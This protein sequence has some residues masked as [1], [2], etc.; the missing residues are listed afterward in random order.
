MDHKR[1]S[2]ILYHVQKLFPRQNTTDAIEV[3]LVQRI[4]SYSNKDKW[5]ELGNQLTANDIVL[6]PNGQ[7]KD[8]TGREICEKIVRYFN[9]EYW[10]IALWDLLCEDAK[11]SPI[12][13]EI[14][15]AFIKH[16]ISTVAKNLISFGPQLITHKSI[17]DD[18]L[19]H[20]TI[21]YQT[22]F[23]YNDIMR[24][25][26]LRTKERIGGYTM[27][28]AKIPTNID[29]DIDKLIKLFDENNQGRYSE[30]IRIIQN[31]KSPTDQRYAINLMACMYNFTSRFL[32]GKSKI[33]KEIKKLSA[34]TE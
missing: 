29:L 18:C 30:L 28:N 7:I 1:E 2:H 26:R 13:R 14:V 9:T 22:I 21:F 5:V 34:V 11:G 32:P 8:Y 3:F 20:Q 10:L 33:T 25:I 19:P 16:C 24:E 6:K 23:S 12:S 31:E 27:T 15:R 4:G 17:N